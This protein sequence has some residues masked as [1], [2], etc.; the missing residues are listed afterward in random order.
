MPEYARALVW[1]RRDLRDFDHA[2]LHHALNQARQ[3][4]C[5][6]IFDRE[7][8]DR[9]PNPADRRVEFIHAS[10]A[11]LQQALAAKGGG[12][13]VRYGVA[14]EEIVRLAAELGVDALFYNHDDDP[15]ALARDA[16]VEAAL[17]T[18]EVSVHHYKDTLIFERDEVL[19]G[20]GTPFS[21]FTPYKNAWLKTLTPSCLRGWP[22]ED[23]D[24]LVPHSTPLPSLEDMGFAPTNLRALKLPTGMAGGAQLF[25]D[26]L[27]RI[28]RYQETRDFPAIKGPSYLSVHLR[29]GTVSIRQLAGAAWQ[30]GGRGAQ[31]WL[32]ELIWRDFYHQVLWHRPEV[33]CGHSFKPQYDALP[34]PDPPGHFEAWCAART[35]YPLIDAAMRQLNQTGYMHNR[36]R[37]VAASFLAKDLLVDWR[38]GER[39]FADTLID[40]DLAANSG[41]WQWAASVGCD[42][43]PWFRIFNPVTQSERFDAAGRFIRRYLPEL[44]GVADRYIHAPWTMPAAEQSRCGVVIGRDYPAPIIDHAVQRVQAL[45]LFR[46]AAGTPADA[47]PDR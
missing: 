20:A 11:E 38:R 34:W 37:M 1:F 2:A 33:A 31:T 26:F 6:F 43:Q 41:G 8:L 32:S 3:V 7:I 39:Y 5:A 27:D 14:R 16:D 35:G 21:V 24:R 4:V 28:D 42:A 18:H 45:A 15:A 44:A 29:F 9:L 13:V 36:L 47:L 25:D 23:T 40:F 17:A 22:V 30:Q 46:S 12:L 10:V 19:T